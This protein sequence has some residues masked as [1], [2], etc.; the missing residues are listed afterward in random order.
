[1]FGLLATTRPARRLRLASLLLLSAGLLPLLADPL[2]PAASWPEATPAELGVAEAPLLAAR[3]YALSAGGSGLVVHQGKVI[4]KWGDPTALYDLKSTSK[5][6]GC[7][8]LGLALKDG[9]VTL[10]DPAIKHLP[11]FGTPPETNRLTGWLERITLRMLAEHTAGFDKPGGFVPLLFAPGT[12]WSYSDAGPNWLADCLTKVYGRD[13]HD[14]LFER[15]FTPLGIRPTDLRWRNHA[16]RPDTLDGI[17]RREFGSGFHAN[18]NAMARIG[19]LHLREGRWHKEIILPPSFVKALHTPDPALAKLPVR[20]P[21]EFGRA[22]AHYRLLWWN[23]TDA[24]LR[25]LPTD[26]FWAWGLYD[27]L[28]VV[29]PSLDLVVARAGSS[30]PRKKGADHYDVLRPFLEPLAAAFLQR[31]SPNRKP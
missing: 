26:A 4:L 7:M 28:I 20:L 30:W 16:Y 24:T 11:S 14:L 3:D 8:V 25:H 27:S 22:S 21:D 17:K 19:Y 2:F 9:K 31:N 12:Q 6:I 23:N 13:L 5:S 15:V 1:M 29:V 18:V 10:D